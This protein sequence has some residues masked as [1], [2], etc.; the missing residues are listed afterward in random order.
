V[1]S[2]ARAY[3][4]TAPWWAWSILEGVP[5]GILTGVFAGSQGLLRATSQGLIGGI[6]FGAVMGPFLSRRARRTQVATA[7]LSRGDVKTAMRSVMRGPVPADPQVR[8]A[9]VA[10]AQLQLR[11]WTRFKLLYLVGFGLADLGT[12]YLAVTSQR[13]VGGV[14]MFSVFLAVPPWIIHRLRQRL[15]LFENSTS[16]V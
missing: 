12:I 15:R 7:G 9:T 8:S 14:V 16:T 1:R 13:F 6:F 4:S 5:F 3:M 10:L 11:D 2:R